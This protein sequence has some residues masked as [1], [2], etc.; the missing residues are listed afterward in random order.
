MA[1]VGFAE[2][3]DSEPFD[4][5]EW[6]EDDLG[7][8][9]AGFYPGGLGTDWIQDGELDLPAVVWVDQAD[10]VREAAAVAELVQGGSG[11]DQA[12][13]LDWDFNLEVGAELNHFPGFDELGL[14]DHQV[15]PGGVFGC[16]SGAV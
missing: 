5:S 4:R 13:V 11:E 6:D 2:G 12:A 16:R 8:P 3:S 9:G 1:T 15:I 14:T 10:R 7:D